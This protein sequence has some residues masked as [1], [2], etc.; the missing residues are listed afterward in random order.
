MLWVPALIFSLVRG[1]EAMGHGDFKLMAMIGAWLGAGSLVWILLAASL[2]GALFHLVRGR[3][4]REEF[5]F[6]PWLAAA[7]VGY[8]SLG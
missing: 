1:V 2:A 3:R 5:A 4:G 6:G 8:G 7:A